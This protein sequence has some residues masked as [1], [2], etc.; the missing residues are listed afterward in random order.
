MTNLPS[1]LHG[2]TDEGW[3]TMVWRGRVDNL[4]VHFRILK[5]QTPD[6][7]AHEKWLHVQ[8]DAAM[9]EAQEYLDDWDASACRK[10]EQ[11]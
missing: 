10:Q 6:E 4:L 2:V 8:I 7:T 9:S 3:G 5:K 11:L 1:A